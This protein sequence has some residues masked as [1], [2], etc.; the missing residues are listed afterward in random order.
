MGL[1]LNPESGLFSV[2]S[3]LFLRNS[4]NAR[5]DIPDEEHTPGL[6]LNGG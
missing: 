1:S 3:R 4:R 5:H 2:N 6:R